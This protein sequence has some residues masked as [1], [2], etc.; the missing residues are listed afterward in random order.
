[1]KRLAQVA[2]LSAASLLLSGRVALAGAFLQ[3]GE[4]GW[5]QSHHELLTWINLL[6][7]VGVLTYLLRRPLVRFFAERLDTIHE[8]LEEGRRALAASG[9]RLSE[10]EKKLND[11]ER[12]IADF[13][14]RSEI[15]MKTERERLQQASERESQRVV[16]FAQAQI[17]AAARAAQLE[18]KRYAAARA[19][20]LAESVIRRHLDEA[21]R[22]KLV[23]QFVD[24]LKESRLRN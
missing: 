23:N 5:G 12:E 6:I 19:V 3:T 13:R 21:S 22:H 8:G 1:M 17:E 9:A 15:E 2:L 10:V 18:L 16:E 7:L 11:L 14:A 20:E 24:Q 4:S